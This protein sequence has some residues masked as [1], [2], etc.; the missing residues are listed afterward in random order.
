MDVRIGL[1]RKL[2]AEELILLYCAGEDSWESLGLQ[3]NPTNPSKRRSVL[4]VHWRTDVEAETPT[5]WPPDVKSWLIWK[6]LDARENWGQVDKGTTGWMASS[7]EWAWVL[8]NSRSWWWTG[9]PGVLR[10]MGSQRV[11][12]DW[13]TELNWIEFALIHGPNIL[14]SYAMLLFTALDFTSITSHIHNWVFFCFGS[15]S[16]FVLE[17]FLHS[18]SVAFWGPTDLGSSSFSVLYFCRFILFMGFLRH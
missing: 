3:G 13:A 15:V 6:D 2:T 7:T 10:F 16:S 12:H 8:G 9:R 1:E 4:G 14:G 5:L 17:L 11:G 18:S